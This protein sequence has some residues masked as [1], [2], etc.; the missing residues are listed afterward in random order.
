MPKLIRIADLRVRS[1]QVDFDSEGGVAD[2][3]VLVEEVRDDGS[4]D[5]LVRTSV[6]L[7]KAHLTVLRQLA[8]DLAAE[9]RAAEGV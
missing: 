6:K 3:S 8:V 2:T 1:V 9:R 5:R 4:T 7:S